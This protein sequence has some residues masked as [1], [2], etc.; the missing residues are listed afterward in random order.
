[1]KDSCPLRRLL[2]VP[3]ALPVDEEEQVNSSGRHL[4]SGLDAIF[5]PPP[6]LLSVWVVLAPAGDN[7]VVVVVVVASR[8]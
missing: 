3:A 2:L 4:Q 6:P 1:V 5:M 7:V 8:V